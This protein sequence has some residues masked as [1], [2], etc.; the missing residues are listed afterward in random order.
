M[1]LCIAWSAG[2]VCSAH[3]VKLFAAHLFFFLSFSDL[4]V[5]LFRLLSTPA[6]PPLFLW[7]YNHN[8]S[9]S[10]MDCI[11]LFPQNGNSS[12]AYIF[13]LPTFQH[14]SFLLFPSVPWVLFNILFHQCFAPPSMFSMFLCHF[15]FSPTVFFYFPFVGDS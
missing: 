3:T 1:D 4:P 11:Y 5:L 13:H 10:F 12:F 8:F 6:V 15:L 14:N 2:F 9:P 7:Q